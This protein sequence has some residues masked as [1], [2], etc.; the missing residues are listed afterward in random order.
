MKIGN[1]NTKK[2]VFIIAEIGNNHEG[3][4]ELA[5]KMIDELVS[6][7]IKFAKIQT[8]TSGNS[9][10]SDK[11]KSANYVEKITDQEETLSGLLERCKLSFEDQIE[12][13]SYAKNKSLLL[14]ST[15][16]DILSLAMTCL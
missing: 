8:Y 5:K 6:I 7:G 3:N 1:I 13:F 9:R 14:F 15:P 11:V 12:L 16:F 2:K 4:F 10:V